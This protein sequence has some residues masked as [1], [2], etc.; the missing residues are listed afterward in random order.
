[1][2]Y[3]TADESLN[4]IFLFVYNFISGAFVI[5]SLKI[6]RDYV[7][8]CGERVGLMIFS[9]YFAL[10]DIL[11]CHYMFLT[12]LRKMNSSKKIS[13]KNPKLGEKGKERKVP[14]WEHPE[15]VPVQNRAKRIEE[16]EKEKMKN[17]IVEYDDEEEEN[18]FG[19]LYEVAPEMLEIEYPK[20]GDNIFKTYKSESV[21]VR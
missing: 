16:M 15:L 20:E 1:M 12:K 3:S 2:D 21:E 7:M 6:Q 9:L 11:P 5:N 17:I 10:Q 8:I 14:T 19:D 18:D 13:Q 4:T